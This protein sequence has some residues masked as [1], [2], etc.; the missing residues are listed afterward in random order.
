MRGESQEKYLM[1]VLAS[2][3]VIPETASKTLMK[4]AEKI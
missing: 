2:K 4:E 1:R 3:G